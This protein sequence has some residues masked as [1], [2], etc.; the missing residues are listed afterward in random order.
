MLVVFEC[1]EQR[2]T[3]DSKLTQNARQERLHRVQI[4]RIRREFLRERREIGRSQQ[5]KHYRQRP[6]VRKISSNYRVSG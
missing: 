1:T 3:E 6:E 4:G 5:R 2:N